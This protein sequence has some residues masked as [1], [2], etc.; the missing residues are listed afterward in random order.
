MTK[1]KEVGI[2]TFVALVLDLHILKNVPL[3]MVEIY[4]LDELV[5]TIV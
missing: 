5:Y 4:V 1:I 3:D 2:R